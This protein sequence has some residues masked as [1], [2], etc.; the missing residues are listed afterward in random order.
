MVKM[1]RFDAI[2]K[3]KMHENAVLQNDWPVC[4]C[5][6]CHHVVTGHT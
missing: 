3:H 6:A 5:V 2:M 4:Y 1:E